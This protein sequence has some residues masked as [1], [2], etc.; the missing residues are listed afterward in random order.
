MRLVRDVMAV[1]TEVDD[2][3]SDLLGWRA[4]ELVGTRTQVHPDDELVASRAWVEFVAA[5]GAERWWRGRYRCAD[6]TWR[7]VET[8]NVNQL[9][10]DGTGRLVTD[11]WPIDEDEAAS[12]ELVQFHD[13]LLRRLTDAIPVGLFQFDH[14]GRIVF[15]NDRL[16]AWLREPAPTT[17]ADIGAELAGADRVVFVSH[18]A[19]VLDGDALDDEEVRLLA[20]KRVC[21]L[22]MRPLTDSTGR[23]SGGVGCLSDVTERVRLRDELERR[24][25]TD[26]LTGTSNRAACF[27]ALQRWLDDGHH[28]TVAFVDLDDFK[29]VNDR[30]GHAAG[31]DAL[32]A[33]AARLRGVCRDDDLVGRLGGDE[34]VV[35][36]RRAGDDRG[37]RTTDGTGGGA[38][39]PGAAGLAT[40]IT[41]ALVEPVAVAGV[42]LHLGA[43]VGIADGDGRT[44]TADT[45]IDRADSSM[46]SRKRS[47]HRA[48]TAEPVA[49]DRDIVA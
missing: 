45:L 25:T 10:I 11:L 17:L 8:R 24:A 43:S 46:Y 28:V 14:L 6:G 16:Q 37:G 2:H 42:R 5:L 9:D 27:A 29:S 36:S 32:V 47:P 26:A 19:S 3:V 18:A 48:R 20:R 1:I 49:R 40:R 38:T 4:D 30:H 21:T 34:F 7:W 31:D 35:A 13:Q 15:V 12:H 33:L 41:E 23:V 22:A 44:D 39:R